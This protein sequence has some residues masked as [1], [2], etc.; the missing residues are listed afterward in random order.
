MQIKLLQTKGNKIMKTTKKLLSV[1][2]SVLMILSTVSTLGMVSFAENTPVYTVKI[3]PSS[4]T[5]PIRNYGGA[6]DINGVEFLA[7][8]VNAKKYTNFDPDRFSFNPISVTADDYYIS[9]GKCFDIIKIEFP[10]DFIIIGGEG[11]SE[12]VWT[13]FA[14]GVNFGVKRG[15]LRNGNFITI[16]YTGGHEK[17]TYHPVQPATCIDEAVETEYWECAKGCGKMLDKDNNVVTKLENSPSINGAHTFADGSEI[18]SVCGLTADEYAAVLTRSCLLD[19]TVQGGPMYFSD[20]DPFVCQ[21]I[22]MEVL[23]PDVSLTATPNQTYGII[24]FYYLIADNASVTYKISLANG[25]HL[26]K[27]AMQLNPTTG[28]SQYYPDESIEFKTKADGL[29]PEVWTFDEATGNYIWEAA[30]DDMTE[31]EFTL[32]RYKDA[33]NPYHTGFDKIAVYGK[34]NYVNGVCEYCVEDCPHN[35]VNYVCTICNTEDTAGK[36]AALAEA[37]TSA[38]AEINAAKTEDNKAIAEKA[39]TDIS[40]ATE[41]DDVATLKTKA[42]TD[43][44]KA[45]ADAAAKALADAKTA[46]IA[47]INSAKTD[48]NKAVAE[49]AITDI[50]AA[51]NI[52]DVAAIK[53]QALTDMAKADEDAAKALADAKAAAVAEVEAAKAAALN[54]AVENISTDAITSATTLAEVA[55]AKTEALNAV[56]A[57][58]KELA[59]AKTA[60]VNALETE[61]GADASDAVKAIVE[62]AKADINNEHRVSRITTVKDGAVE[63]IKEQKAIEKAQAEAKAL[64]DAKAEAIEALQ[65][66]VADEKATD[67]M[68][69]IADEGIEAVNA[70]TSIEEVEA[71][72]AKYTNQINTQKNNEYVDGDCPKI[73]TGFCFTFRAYRNI[74]VIGTFI[75]IIHTI[76]HLAHSFGD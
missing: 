31:L 20:S 70:A 62:T 14:N 49:K 47:E 2:L 39:I 4:L 15:T 36:A 37:K 53:T 29:D 7:N 38:V 28:C 1:L 24:L 69:A 58:E 17:G 51:T 35:F 48:D 50:N 45:D 65:A 16:T 34:H 59:D 32:T 60:A 33:G 52:D 5:E 8:T 71:L 40:S 23:S 22:K 42:I 56:A 75:T 26:S 46:A 72:L 55:A 13:G 63:A 12:N 68:K 54:Y 30:D 11:W 21:N 43:M 27:I 74:P 3:G 67:K 18:C 6:F 41:I 76:I 44:A 61:A 10:S 66:L 25:D 19:G 57:A 9:M 73:V 64:A